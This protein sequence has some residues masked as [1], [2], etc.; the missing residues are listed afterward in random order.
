MKTIYGKIVTFR[1]YTVE[2]TADNPQWPEV[3]RRLLDEIPPDR[4]RDVG[5]QVLRDFQRYEQTDQWLETPNVKVLATAAL[6]SGEEGLAQA[7]AQ[8][9]LGY[10]DARKPDPE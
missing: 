6:I 10:R 1:G 8:T 5:M 2:V 9:E 7:V 4:V 3:V